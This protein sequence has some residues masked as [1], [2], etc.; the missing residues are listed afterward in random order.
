MAMT[1][2]EDIVTSIDSHSARLNPLWSTVQT[3]LVIRLDNIGDVLMLSPALKAIKETLP[4]S[5]ITLMA[6]PSGS[7][8]AAL[9]PWVDDVLTVRSL[10]QALGNV[11]FNPDRDWELIRTVRDCQFDA[12]FVFTSFSQTPYPAGYLCYLAGIP[13][14]VGESK[15]WGGGIFTTELKSALDE[16]HQVDRNLRLVEAVG[17]SVGDRRLSIHIP[18]TIQQQVKL[19]L[20]EQGL[21]LDDPYILLSPWASCQARTYPAQRFAIAAGHLS[22]ITGYKIVITGVA[23][24]LPYTAPLLRH[25]GDSAVNLIGSTNLTEL[26]ALVA[27]A[28]LI[29][30]NNTSTLHIADAT[31]TPSVILFSGTDYESQW[32]PRYTKAQLL[33]QPT[34]C[35]PCYAL[36]CPYGLECLDISPQQI[37]EAGIEL[38]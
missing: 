29:L 28:K 18:N 6:S 22:K 12:A 24:D 11:E 2:A 5:R 16:I 13:L 3:I 9:L 17:F 8:A 10:W 33:R 37:V 38:L 20:Y 23:K 30:T 25:L 4:D 36:I 27:S 1:A 34:F 15:E 14:R 35:S 19:Q 26:A 31:G 32:Q 21:A 7:Q